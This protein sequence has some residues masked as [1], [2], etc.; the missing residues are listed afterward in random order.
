M[1]QM[2]FDSFRISIYW[3]TFCFTYVFSIVHCTCIASH[4]N[5]IGFFTYMIV[6]FF[7]FL[8]IRRISIDIT[9]TYITTFHIFHYMIIIFLT[10]V[11]I[12]RHRFGIIWTYIRTCY[13]RICCN[14]TIGIMSKISFFTCITWIRRIFIGIVWTYIATCIIH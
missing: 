14:R 1:R 6:V 5:W 11:T 10:R 3:F 12:T 8:T 4:N 9:G 13:T 7:A 2:C